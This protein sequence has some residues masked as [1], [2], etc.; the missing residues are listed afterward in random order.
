MKKYIY[1]LLFLGLTSYVSPNEKELVKPVKL[2][3]KVQKM[4]TLGLIGG[5]SWHSTLDY[6]STINQTVND[7]FGNNTNP[8]LLVYTLNQAE[9]HRF[10]TQDKWDSI[11]N[12][13][14]NAALNL[15]KAGA[16]SVMFCA[17]TPHK[18]YN[19]VQEQLDFPVIHIADATAKAIKKKGLKKVCFIGTKYSM[20]EDFITKRIEENGLEV[21]VPEDEKVIDELHRIIIEEL[22]YGTVKPESKAYVLSVINNMINDGAEGVILGC[23]EFPLMIF[24]EDLEVPAF[25]TTKIHSLSAVDFILNE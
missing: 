15:N 20:E 25:D 18:V 3:I 23:T 4:H 13:L 19:S 10:Q 6:Y 14:T 17:N 9:V 16:E 8:P 21:L 1:G 5:T 2:E 22:T 7:H 24:Q 11:A 12:M